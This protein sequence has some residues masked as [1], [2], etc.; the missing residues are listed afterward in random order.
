MT[1]EPIKQ[2]SAKID[3]KIS[4]NYLSLKAP[5]TKRGKTG[6]NVVNEHNTNMNMT[7]SLDKRLTHILSKEKIKNEEAKK[8]SIKKVKKPGMTSLDHRIIS[9]YTDRKSVV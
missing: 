3:N 1:P 8:K 2:N 6:L 9:V 4:E 5:I 7:K